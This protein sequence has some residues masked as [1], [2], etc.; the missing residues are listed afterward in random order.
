MVDVAS[1][2]PALLAMLFT[3]KNREVLRAGVPIS[4]GACFP[5]VLTGWTPAIFPYEASPGHFRGNGVLPV[6]YH[7]G[8]ARYS[9]LENGADAAALDHAAETLQKQC[10]FTAFRPVFSRVNTRRVFTGRASFHQ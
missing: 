5:P 2:I 3:G 6:Y 7:R 1:A 8:S 4:A 9:P 10:R